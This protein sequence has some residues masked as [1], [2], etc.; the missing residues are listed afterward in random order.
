M[1]QGFLA[2]FLVMSNADYGV[3]IFAGIK[4]PSERNQLV[5]HWTSLIHLAVLAVGRPAWIQLDLQP[6]LSVATYSHS[7]KIYEN[8]SNQLKATHLIL[9]LLNYFSGGM[10]RSQLAIITRRCGSLAITNHC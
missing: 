4:I 9:R 3:C 1:T 6:C 5:Q 7:W 2:V 8:G 10:G